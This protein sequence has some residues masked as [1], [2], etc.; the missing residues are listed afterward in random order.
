MGLTAKVCRKATRR[1]TFIE[2]DKG[3]KTNWAYDS[4]RDAP[5]MAGTRRGKESNDWFNRRSVA[6]LDWTVLVDFRAVSSTVFNAATL[7]SSSLHLAYTFPVP[8][9]AGAKLTRDTKRHRTD[10]PE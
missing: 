5:L 10:K 3:Q 1:T 2:L 9:A 8:D 6:S 4:D 7:I